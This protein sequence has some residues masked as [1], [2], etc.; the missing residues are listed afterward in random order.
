MSDI[1]LDLEDFKERIN[2]ELVANIA[3]F[4]YRVLSFTNKNFDSQITTGT[5]ENILME[6]KAIALESLE[7][8][9][10]YELRQASQSISRLSALG[11]KYFQENEPW[12]LIKT[13]K[14]K[15]QQVINTAV[16]IL[17]DLIIVLKPLLPEYSSDV[18]SQLNLNE[19]SLK[20]LD[21]R[22]H[23]HKVN[24]AKIIFEKIEKIEL[25]K[26]NKS[27]VVSP[28]DKLQ[29]RVAEIKKVEKHPTAEKLYIE[30]IDFGDEQRVI[31]S[32]LVPHYNEAELLGRK[33][34]VVTNLEP[35]NLR[36][37]NSN[38]MLL[39]AEE[40]GVVGLLIPDA[41]LGSYIYTADID[42]SKTDA[43]ESEIS[44]IKNLPR[45]KINTFAEAKIL[46]KDGKVYCNEK[47]LKVQNGTI[48]ID[49]VQNGKVR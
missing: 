11:N 41:E 10:K 24:D 12:K 35:A 19:P 20:N 5:D 38:G 9:E 17:K 14:E 3:N 39:A 21:L 2:N 26:S 18:S 22:M 43:I 28:F 36:G 40:K 49:K 16:N 37:V 4:V 13:D 6:A 1:N 32:G 30:H 7:Y 48:S 46:A 45:I 8:Y 25:G 34:I 31:V 15:A 44:R 33:I 42:E 47:E 27:G 23:N 29:L